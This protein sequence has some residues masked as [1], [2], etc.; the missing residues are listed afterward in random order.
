MFVIIKGFVLILLEIFKSIIMND[1]KGIIRSIWE[2]IFSILDNFVL[3]LCKK[4]L[5]SNVSVDW[6]F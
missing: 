4:M 2:N 1:D 3:F 5:G 6:N